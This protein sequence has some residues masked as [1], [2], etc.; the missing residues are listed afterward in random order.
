M[1]DYGMPPDRDPKDKKLAQARI[2][3]AGLRDQNKA[4]KEALG[5][6]LEAMQAN[7]AYAT[8]KDEPALLRG[9]DAAR[10]VLNR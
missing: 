6:A 2:Q 3:C 1:S 8:R 5:I 4:L 9:I 7:I 10:K